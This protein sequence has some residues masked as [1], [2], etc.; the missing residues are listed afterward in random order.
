MREKDFRN[1]MAQ[2]M[3]RNLWRKLEYVPEIM[4][5][6]RWLTGFLIDGG[7]PVLPNAVGESG[8]LQADRCRFRAGERRGVAGRSGLDLK[9]L[10]WPDRDQGHSF[11]G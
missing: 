4:A 1:G 10:G 8:P 5:H 11:G 9:S 2:L 7:M 6:P 3:G